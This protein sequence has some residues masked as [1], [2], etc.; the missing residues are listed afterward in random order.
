MRF[1]DTGR[2]DGFPTLE[3][4]MYVEIDLRA[5]NCTMVSH[6]AMREFEVGVEVQKYP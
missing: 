3:A 5:K 1:L 2:R 6:E 4:G